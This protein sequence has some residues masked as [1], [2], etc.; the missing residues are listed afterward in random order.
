MDPKRFPLSHVRPF[1]RVSALD[2]SVA[3]QMEASDEP[4]GSVGADTDPRRVRYKV[5][6]PLDFTEEPN[7]CFEVTVD[8]V[9][10]RA[11]GKTLTRRFSRMAWACR[12][13][14]P[15]NRRL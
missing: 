7:N 6:P 5:R 9:G 4:V 13:A 10:P 11:E 1:L 8:K 15:S 12:W 14:G 2:L 3:A